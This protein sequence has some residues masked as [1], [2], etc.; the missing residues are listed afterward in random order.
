[1]SAFRN[2]FR[3][4][5]F[6]RVESG[7][8]GFGS[9][10]RRV[11]SARDAPP[12]DLVQLNFLSLLHEQLVAPEQEPLGESGETERPP[13][14][15]AKPRAHGE[16]LHRPAGVARVSLYDAQ[17]FGD[18]AWSKAW[19]KA[20]LTAMEELKEK[21][22]AEAKERAILKK[23]GKMLRRTFSSKLY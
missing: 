18:I 20:T 1:M 12:L 22:D 2:A 15:N 23:V 11:C 5:R 10:P 8:L 13:A 4:R 3:K 19:E 14:P 17:L 16:R 6:V 21:E 7:F 9:A